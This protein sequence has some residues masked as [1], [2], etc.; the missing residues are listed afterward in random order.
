MICNKLK[1]KP[2]EMV[3]V[4]DHKEFDY[5]VPK[6]V[7]IQSFYLDRNGTSNGEF[8]VSNLEEFEERI[9]KLSV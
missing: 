6:K 3:H 5:Q 4:G 9:G 8:V 7:G 1:I 2:S